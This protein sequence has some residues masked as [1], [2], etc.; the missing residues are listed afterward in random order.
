M[1]LFAIILASV[2]IAQASFV[3]CFTVKHLKFGPQYNH[4][5][6]IVSKCVLNEYVNRKIY[7]FGVKI[8]KKL[9][10]E[11]YLLKFKCFLN[12]SNLVTQIDNS[13]KMSNISKKCNL[14]V[15]VN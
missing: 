5:S 12:F 6:P 2:H 14:G 1:I 10:F 7:D 13:F 3:I 9:Q 15:G 8:T 11:L 4:E